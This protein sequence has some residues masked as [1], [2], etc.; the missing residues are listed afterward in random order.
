M[1]GPNRYST[2]VAWAK[3]VLPLI[4]LAL[5]ST[6]FLF[7]RT[8]NPEDALPF[9]EVDM[10]QLA[11]QQRLSRPRFAGTLE[12]GR[13]ITLSAQTASQDGGDPNLI[14]LSAVD[15]EMTLTESDRVS[16]QADSGDFDLATQ[17]IDLMGAVRAATTG[18]Y[19]L[20][21]EQLTLV[22][23]SMHLTSPGAV[24]VSGSGLSLEAGAMELTGSEGQALFSFTGGV[25]LLYVPGD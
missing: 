2:L 16:L 18:G 5:L 7:S 1:A 15:A 3:V 11:S 13:P 14:H 9:A 12:D 6:L 20:L 22:L 24:S 17:V 23:E 4:A 25:R 8:P 10:E 19:S 21:S